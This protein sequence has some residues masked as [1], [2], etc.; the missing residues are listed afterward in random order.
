MS[1]LFHLDV[2]SCT[3]VC[4]HIAVPAVSLP[5]AAEPSVFAHLSDR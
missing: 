5:A 1:N 3:A 4:G 2:F